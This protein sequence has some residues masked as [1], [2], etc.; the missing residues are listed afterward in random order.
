MNQPIQSIAKLLDQTNVVSSNS[1]SAILRNPLQIE[2]DS[3]CAMEQWS[4]S[5]VVSRCDNTSVS[6]STFDYDEHLVIPSEC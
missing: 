3:Q 2:M 6:H 5:E 4:D 1:K